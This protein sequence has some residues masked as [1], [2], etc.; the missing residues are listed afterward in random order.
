[1]QNI[2]IL[3]ALLV[4]FVVCN[5]NPS[6]FNYSSNSLDVSQLKG[7]VGIMVEFVDENTDDPLTSGNGRFL[8]E[9]PDVS[10]IGYEGINRC[11][12]TL[13]DPPPHTA[14]YFTSQ[15]I[16]ARNYFNSIS[17][18]NINF[19]YHMIPIVYQVD[20]T[21]ASYAQSENDIT[22]LYIESI[23]AAEDEIVYQ[24]DLNNWDSEDFLVV[25]FH[26]GLGQE[27]GSGG[28]LFDPTV[29]DIHSAYIDESMIASM[30]NAYS[31]EY[32]MCSGGICSFDSGSYLVSNGILLPETL[33]SIYYDTIEDMYSLALI[34]EDELENIFCE[35][36]AGMTGLFTY[37]LGYRLGFPVMHSTEN[38]QPVTRIGKFGLMDQ[39][40]F[41]GYGLMPALPHVWSRINHPDL[42]INLIDVTIDLFNDEDNS[43]DLEL[44]SLDNSVHK[45]KIS[46]NEY[47]LI[48]NR[49]NKIINHTLLGDG[50]QYTIQ[51]LLFYLNCD[52]VNEDTNEENWFCDETLQNSLKSLFNEPNYGEK[53]Y[54]LDI[55]SQLFPYSFNT[56]TNVIE[57]FQNFDYGLPGSGILIWHIKEPSV[58]EINQGMNNDINNKAIHLEEADGMLNIGYPDPNPFGSP[59]PLG[60]KSDFWYDGNFYNEEINNSED[61][62]FNQSSI[63]N[64]N[65]NGGIATNISIKI[66]SNIGTT[67]NITISYENDDI[68]MIDNSEFDRIRHLGNNGDGVMYYSL[69]DTINNTDK[70]YSKDYDSSTVLELQAINFEQLIPGC[71]MFDS[72]DENDII[73]FTDMGLCIA[74]DNSWYI[75]N[76]EAVNVNINP[77]G[78]FTA[79]SLEANG[80]YESINVNENT[81]YALGDLDDDGLDE[82]ISVSNG[83]LTVKDYNGLIASGF[84]VSLDFEGIPLVS[85]TE[86]NETTEIIC[87]TKNS[88]VVLSSSGEIIDELPLY[89]SDADIYLLPKDSDT[90]LLVN[91]NRTIEF[92]SNEN[93]RFWMNPFSQVNNF[94]LVGI[95]KSERS[96]R[97]D[98]WENQNNNSD[99]GL[100]LT[101]VF[102]YPNPFEDETKFRFFVGSSSLVAVKIYNMRGYLLDNFT[103]SSLDKYQFNE[104]L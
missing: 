21:M 67:M 99:F 70:W 58:Y 72:K 27:A 53:Y 66:N 55:V 62:I 101:R 1:M 96:F 65:D 35:A 51:E 103:I 12:E 93:Y 19:D 34:E 64:S 22:R 9:N 31:D 91:G 87:K 13:L 40:Q 41:N 68:I 42:D 48:E 79:N 54:F 17:D 100:D 92:D 52:S 90:V 4:S 3:S 24:A 84:P 2:L 37:L 46:E 8:T 32:D 89:D 83:I 85:D 25:V 63:P 28:A 104:Y 20:E 61:I 5:I 50:T 86:G 6:L 57:D 59:L 23:I 14:Q 18:D 73:L 39:G 56:T 82:I 95:G 77:L 78:Y 10:F 60:W 69:I 94:P 81:A 16:A 97:Y 74:G 44:S 33:N 75:K 29:Y 47:F 11:S 45:I 36:Q 30:Y 26:A 71:K 49:N 80:T 43:I 15:I 76:N 98:N 88:I 102:N 38:I 7:I